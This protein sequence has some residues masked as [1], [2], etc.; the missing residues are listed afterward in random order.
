MATTDKANM[1]CILSIL[2]EYSDENHIL[3]Q[4]EIIAKMQTLYDRKVDR[5]TIYAALD[6]LEDFGYEISR[7]EANGKGYYIQ[8]R[9]FSSAEIKLLIDAIYSC[10]YISPRQTEE[11][12]TKLRS[13]LSVHERKNFNYTNIIAP[14]KKSP[15]S[16]MFLNIEIIDEAINDKKKISFIYLD[17][18]YDKTLKP[19]RKELYIANPYIMVCDSANYYL[20]AITNRHSDIGY[21]RIDMMKDIKVLDESIDVSKKDAKL[22]SVKKVVYAFSGQPVSV[23]LHCDKT[24]LRYV[25]EKF[26]KD[27]IIQKNAD[28]SFDAM[29]KA[30]PKGV[31]YWALQY[32]DSVEVVSPK[33]IRD[34]VKK[35]I[36][37]NKYY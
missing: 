6:A 23:H 30:A 29:F 15:N 7:Y 21:Y 33:E 36:K 3:T 31:V 27:I 35:I 4:K 14:D 9:K 28:G 18:D 16:E 26:G 10:Q 25:I 13:F 11:L 34:E 1:L 5:R 22:D 20:V 32:L 37:D 19:R 8:E 2:E 24:A 12:L 17:Y